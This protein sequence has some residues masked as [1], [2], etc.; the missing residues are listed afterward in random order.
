MT[1]STNEIFDQICDIMQPF[2]Q[3]SVDIKQETTFATD[4]ELDSLSVMDMLAAIEDHFDV[5]VPLN[6]LPDLETVGQVAEAIKNILD[7]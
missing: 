7:E 6:I 3:K 5:T 1:L 4:L 2:N